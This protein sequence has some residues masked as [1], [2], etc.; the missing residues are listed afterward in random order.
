MLPIHDI[1]FLLS[2][3][4]KWLLLLGFTLNFIACYMV[5]PEEQC[6]MTRD[7]FQVND[8]RIYLVAKSRNNN[9]LLVTG[10]GSFFAVNI[11]VDITFGP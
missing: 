4:F 11:P 10:K 2:G 3:I 6:F 5:V 8:R 9:L 1:N 7:E